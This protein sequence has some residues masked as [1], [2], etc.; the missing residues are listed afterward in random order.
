MTNYWL[1]MIIMDV[2]APLRLS[3]YDPYPTKAAALEAL[4]NTKYPLISAWIDED[5]DGAD[6]V[7]KV[8]WHKCYI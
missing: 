2:G 3:I 4:Y 5:K 6:E 8:V 1:S 7:L